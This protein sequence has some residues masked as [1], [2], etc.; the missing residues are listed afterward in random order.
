MWDEIKSRDFTKQCVNEAESKAFIKK[1]LA[2][3]YP[4]SK[5]P[6]VYV[7]FKSGMARDAQKWF[8]K[9]GD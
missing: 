7:L 5:Y 9:D 6:V 1:T 2:E 8:Y 3:E 4:P